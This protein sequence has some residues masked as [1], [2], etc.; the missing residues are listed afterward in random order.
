[1]SSFFICSIACMTFSTF[2]ASGSCIILLST[3][4]T[5]CQDRSSGRLAQLL[6]TYLSDAEIVL[7]K[8]GARLVPVV[9][10]VACALPALAICVLMGGVD[11]LAL[12]GAFLLEFLTRGRSVRL[13]RGW[14]MGLTLRWPVWPW[15]LLLSTRRRHWRRPA[16]RAA[17]LLRLPLRG[18]ATQNKS[19]TDE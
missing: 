12:A 10:L 19:Q 1:M 7:G 5:I 2:F 13:T 9:G 15:H 8:L 11:P 4:G 6:A 18:S 3:A 16:S 17:R 14:T